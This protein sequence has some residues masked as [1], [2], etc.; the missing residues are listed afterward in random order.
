MAGVVAK[1][2][3][4]ALFSLALEEN[5][6]K[7]LSEEA[8]TVLEV[9]K[10]NPELFGFYGNPQISS[11]EKAA[12]TENCFKGRVSDHMTGFLLSVSANGRVKEL[13]AIL[14]EFRS[15]VREYYRIGVAYITTPSELGEGLKQQL[16]K[17]L[18]ETTRYESFELYYT[19]DASLI[20]GIRIRIGDRVVDS[21]IE[22]ELHRMTKNLLMTQIG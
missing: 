11:E 14:K 8:D 15:E 9:L 12:F 20:G 13:P 3:G 22:T 21:S 19:V 17:R 4:H 2:Y 18:L 1:T 16:L 5:S 7:E 6:V 10:D